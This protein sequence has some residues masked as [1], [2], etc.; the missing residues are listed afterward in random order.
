M[1]KAEE[2]TVQSRG[3][4]CSKPIRQMLPGSLAPDSATT[5]E[6]GGVL[7][8]FEASLV[9]MWFERGGFG[10]SSTPSVVTA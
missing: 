4:Y 5:C 1:F 6:D 10:D 8:W 9:L 2:N 3:K 7:M